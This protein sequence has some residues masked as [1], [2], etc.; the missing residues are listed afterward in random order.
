MPDLELIDTI[1]IVMMENRSFDHMLG[2]L[3]LPRIGRRKDVDGLVSR[4]EAEYANP[5]EGEA[6][7]PFHM[8]SGPLPCDL[9][10]ERDEVQTQL[11]VSDVVGGPTMTGFVEA[12]H[13]FTPVN[14]TRRPAPMGFLT[15]REIP[16]TDFLARSFAVCDRWFA[17]LPAS[18]HPNRLMAISGYSERDVTPGALLPDQDLLFD[19]LDR[20]H[21]RWRVYSAGL[22]FFALLPRLWDDILGDRFRPFPRLFDDIRSEGPATFPQVILVEPDY[23]DSP[24]HTSGQANDNHPP[25]AT[26]FGEQFLRRVYQALTLEP[27]RWSRMV[28]IFTYDEHGGFFDHVPP[29]RLRSD[30]P[31]GVVYPPFETTGVRVPAVVVSPFVEAGSVCKQV[32]D[33][34]S[35]LQLIAERFDPGGS[36]YSPEVN[37]R[38]AAGIGSVSAA[39]TRDSPRRDV[40]N[41]PLGPIEATA[42]LTQLR[43]TRSPNQEAFEEAA[44][45]LVEEHP[46]EVAEQHPELVA[47]YAM[48]ESSGRRR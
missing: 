10:H 14:R 16:I 11:A 21:V 7:H 18:T 38:R 5:F 42:A 44:A 9:P 31:A 32:L 34:T 13:A 48:K 30:P 41:V 33:H 43:I 24:V 28:A 17:P 15:P 1:V 6:Y 46:K 26:G 23:E 20:H 3:R 8:S 36:G 4:K 47:W 2:Y 19:W 22:S 25:L 37:A 39:L 45:R 27:A 12:Y 40:P 35:V 29:I